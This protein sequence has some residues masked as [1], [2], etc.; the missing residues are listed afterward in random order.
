MPSAKANTQT[1]HNNSYLARTR[2]SRASNKSI[3][4]SRRPNKAWAEVGNGG[5]VLQGT[6]VLPLK[7]ARRAHMIDFWDLPRLQATNA[8][9]TSSRA[10]SCSR[11]TCVP[12]S[13]VSALL[14][15][16]PVARTLTLTLC[17]ARGTHKTRK[18]QMVAAIPSSSSLSSQLIL[19]VITNLTWNLSCCY[20]DKELLL[21][22]LLPPPPLLTRARAIAGPRA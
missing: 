12:A 5:D 22:P 11:T 4:A 9:S 13:C 14:F 17:L 19:M 15:L 21:P 10:A 8:F 1:T 7:T 20:C 18:Q 16:R 2:A 6:V 3:P